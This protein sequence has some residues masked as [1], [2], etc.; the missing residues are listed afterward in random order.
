MKTRKRDGRL[1]L[2]DPSKI[3]AAIQKAARAAGCGDGLLS[4][5]LASVVTLF[6]EKDFSDGVI[7]TREIQ[8]TVERVLMETGHTEIARAFLLYRERRERMKEVVQVRE[9]DDGAAQAMAPEVDGGRGTTISPWSKARIISALITE[10]E[11]PGD[12]A[13]EIATEVESKVFRSGLTRI[14]S[15]LIR[16]LVDNELFNRGLNRRLLNQSLLGVPG[17]DLRKLVE[18]DGDGKT[19]ADVAMNVAGSVLQ[20]YALRWIHS[21]EEAE[22]HLRGDARINGLQ[23]PSGYLGMELD[24][25]NLPAPFGGPSARARYLGPCVLF[26]ERFV[27]RAVRVHVTDSVL[28]AY[29]SCGVSPEDYAEEL[30]A[31]LA[32]GPANRHARTGS[33]V[34]CL[35]RSLTSSRAE[36]LKAANIQRKA[37]IRFLDTIVLAFLDAAV[38][39]GREL[40]LPMLHLDL[41]GDAFPDDRLLAKAVILEAA[42]RLTMGFEA[43]EE[44]SGSAITPVM[45]SVSLALE[46]VL[47]QSR[48]KAGY[49]VA[50]EL[51]SSLAMAASALFS[52]CQYMKKLHRKG[53]GPKASIRRFLG[54]DGDAVDS[55]Y[56]QVV[57]ELLLK[58]LGSLND[59]AGV[60]GKAHLVNS[61]AIEL[62]H[63]LK[64]WI[65]EEADKPEF[66]VKIAAP[67]S[68]PFKEGL[69]MARTFENEEEALR[70]TLAWRSC[71]ALDPLPECFA[72]E[73]ERRLTFVRMVYEAC[74][75]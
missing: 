46:S 51:R 68:G 13:N 7:P 30:L 29:C 31:S 72:G 63:L 50:D 17:Y 15:S 60:S 73:A 44:R 52:K 66:R 22:A 75:E 67:W 9:S 58:D 57:P 54:G 25:L 21:T 10:A 34:I 23:Y 11:I 33:T 56:V 18:S 32:C 49:P 19:P 64:D 20:Q 42:D 2:F 27:A 5:E 47:R 38:K 26:L 69:S 6:L 70:W 62:A 14:S 3:A 48:G 28:H 8:E 71:F 53:R 37:A 1:D 41:A 55:G 74:S 36:I 40:S 35:S 24:P 59:P 65:E 43:R 39:L 16:E 61:L 4:E 12:M 45:G